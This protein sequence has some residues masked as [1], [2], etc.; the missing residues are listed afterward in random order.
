MKR[1]SEFMGYRTCIAWDAVSEAFVAH[2]VRDTPFD[3]SKTIIGAEVKQFTP[4]KTTLQQ[5]PHKIAIGRT[6]V[7]GSE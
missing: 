5:Y 3:K 7:M 6:K 2:R 4:K 1:I